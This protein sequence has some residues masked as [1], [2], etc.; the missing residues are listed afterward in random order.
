MMYIQGEKP[1][2]F[3]TK[4]TNNNANQTCSLSQEAIRIDGSVYEA[5]DQQ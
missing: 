3:N 4:H 1:R 2:G 5:R